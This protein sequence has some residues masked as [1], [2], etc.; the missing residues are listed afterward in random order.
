MC[1]LCKLTGL[2]MQCVE[3]WAINLADKFDRSL[4]RFVKP[5]L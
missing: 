1:I 5:Y 4:A 3:K 2:Q